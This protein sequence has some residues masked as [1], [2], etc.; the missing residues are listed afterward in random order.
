[1]C[2][3]VDGYFVLV[4]WAVLGLIDFSEFLTQAEIASV[5]YRIRRNESKNQECSSL[6]AGIISSSSKA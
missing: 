4:C 1:M 2:S 5:S 3:V 6:L